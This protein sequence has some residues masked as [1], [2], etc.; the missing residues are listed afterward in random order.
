[1]EVL[2]IHRHK[3][4]RERIEKKFLSGG[5]LTRTCE[6]GLDGLMTARYA[7]FDLILTGFDLPVL[8]GTELIR[9]LRNMS[10]N[11][12]TP[13]LFFDAPD[14]KDWQKSIAITLN[15]EVTDLEKLEAEGVGTFV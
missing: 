2:I 11:Q 4:V 15:A 6:N 14:V 9:S 13:A 12:N 3:S 5:W 7:R 1:M 8:S 10:V